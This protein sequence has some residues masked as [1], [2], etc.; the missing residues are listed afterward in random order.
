MNLPS[1]GEALGTLFAGATFEF[2][3]A[4]LGLARVAVNGRA[5]PV[6]LLGHWTRFDKLVYTDTFDVTELPRE[7]K[8]ALAIELGNGFYNPAPP[9][10]FGKYNLRRRLAEVGTPAVAAVLARNGGALVQT[11]ESWRLGH[12]RLLFNNMYLGEVCDLALLSFDPAEL[13]GHCL[14]DH[15]S[16]LTDETAGFGTCT[17]DKEF[18]G[19]CAQLWSLAC[20][21]EAGQRADRD[22]SRYAG[23]A[24]R[25]R[26]AIRARF[27]HGDGSFG[28]GTQ[29]ACAF[30]GMLGLGD[31][32]RQAELLVADFWA[33]GGWCTRC[34]PCS[35]PRDVRTSVSR[36]I[37]V[38]E[39]DGSILGGESHEGTAHQRKSAQ[40][41]RYQFGARDGGRG[42][43]GRRVRE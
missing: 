24:E 41:G 8:N 12:G 17:P 20:I 30:A 25:L 28:D 35:M 2:A 40:D 34:I 26:A 27:A 1:S 39:S 14:G 10:L 18:F 15:G 13:A 29:S 6:E 11:D 32:G 21:A 38:G 42:P 31:A 22:A 37:N 16:I 36:G 33:H 9:T 5:L 4:V 19:W 7:G 43:C 3:L 23:A